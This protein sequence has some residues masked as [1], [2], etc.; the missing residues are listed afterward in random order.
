MVAKKR[1]LARLLMLVNL[2]PPS[3][4]S[5]AAGEVDAR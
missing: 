1:K 2:K 3:T 5:A 4:V